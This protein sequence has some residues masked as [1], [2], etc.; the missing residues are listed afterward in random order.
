METY[1]VEAI[2]CTLF[3]FLA[4]VLIIAVGASR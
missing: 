1:P 4:L 3:F 2:L